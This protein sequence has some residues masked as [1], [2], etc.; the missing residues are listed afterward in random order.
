M[1]TKMK[2]CGESVRVEKTMDQEM[3]DPKAYPTSLTN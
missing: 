2:P 1:A 3:E